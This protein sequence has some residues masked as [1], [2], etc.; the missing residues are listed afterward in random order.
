MTDNLET[1][2]D[3]LRA[4]ARTSGA[5]SDALLVKPAPGDWCAGVVVGWDR[6]EAP[7]GTVDVLL[8]AAVRTS[9]GAFAAGEVKRLDLDGAVLRGELA[10]DA[11]DPPACGALVYVEAQGERTSARGSRYRAYTVRKAAPTPDSLAAV[12]QAAAQAPQGGGPSAPASRDDED[13][14]FRASAV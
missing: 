2:F 3:D 4:E 8:L 6:R 9:G 7:F 11:E 12:S 5:P 13:I 10:Q 1:A 14:P